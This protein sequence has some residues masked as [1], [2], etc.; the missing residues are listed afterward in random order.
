MKCHA[1]VI[2]DDPDILE[3]VKD[4]LESLGHTCDCVTCQNDAQAHIRKCAYGFI[5]LDLEIPLQYGKPTRKQNGQNLL[6]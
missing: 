4:R 3:D 2:D 5:L 1:L 6:K